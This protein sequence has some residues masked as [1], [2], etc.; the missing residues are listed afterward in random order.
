MQPFV[1]AHT[2]YTC[3]DSFTFRKDVSQVNIS[4]SYLVSF[5]VAGLFTKIL[6]HETIDIT[7]NIVFDKN[8]NIKILK[9]DLK[10]L[11]FD[12]I[13]TRHPNITFCGKPWKSKL[14]KNDRFLMLS[15]ITL[16]NQPQPVF[17]TQKTFTGLLTNYLKGTRGIK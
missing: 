6:L 17:S 7:V 2:R 16:Q 1:T 12:Y 5:H 13:N 9:S 14:L 10:D 4:D 11:F 3:K 15:L 8:P